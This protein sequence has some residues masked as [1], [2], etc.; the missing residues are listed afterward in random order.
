MGTGSQVGKLD[1]LLINHVTSSHQGQMHPHN[2][3]QN[4]SRGPL[5]ITVDKIC[6]HPINGG[7]LS[8]LTGQMGILTVDWQQGN[9]R[10]ARRLPLC[11]HGPFQAEACDSALAQAGSGTG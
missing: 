7:F 9:Q 11:Q 10:M 6:L 4:S 1:L 3:S 5:P 2:P 8:F